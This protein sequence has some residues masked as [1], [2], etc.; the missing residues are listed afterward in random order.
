MIGGR[1]YL[2]KKKKKKKKKEK[3]WDVL[4]SGQEI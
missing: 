1:L 3:Y 4:K 2:K